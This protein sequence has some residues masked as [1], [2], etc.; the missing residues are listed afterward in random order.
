MPV[1]MSPLNTALMNLQ[2]TAENVPMPLD[3]I[4]NRR[5]RRT[6]EK[7]QKHEAVSKRINAL[8]S[9]KATSAAEALRGGI[10]AYMRAGPK[11]TAAPGTTAHAQE[12]NELA[13]YYTQSPYVQVVSA[14]NSMYDTATKKANENIRQEKINGLVA[15]G[16][17]LNEAT[18]IVDKNIEVSSNEFGPTLVNKATATQRPLGGGRMQPPGPSQAVAQPPSVQQP[19]SQTEAVQAPSMMAA[20]KEGT[21]PISNLQQGISNLFGFVSEGQFFPENTQA[22]QQLSLF[23][24][25][26]MKGLVESDRFPVYEQQVVKDL[27][28]TPEQILRDPDDAVSNLYQLKS[29]LEQNIASNEESINNALITPKK[30]GEMADKNDVMRQVLQLMGDTGN[31]GGLSNV[32]QKI[33][34]GTATD[35]EIEQ[36]LSSQVK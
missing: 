33:S 36:Y 5:G 3:A 8:S 7:I 13:T 14:G 6:Q 25:F 9:S 10:E 24:K 18:D 11:I 1:N 30:R 31:P 2:R 22:R 35:D 27:L 17:S 32:E 16:K 28:P 12:W 15:R 4:E 23:N 20:A 26:A 19:Q 21:G 34:D 29:F